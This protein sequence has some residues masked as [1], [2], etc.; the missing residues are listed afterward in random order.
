MSQV[1]SGENWYENNN[2]KM[3]NVYCKAGRTQILPSSLDLTYFTRLMIMVQEPVGGKF[4]DV[5]VQVHDRQD[6]TSLMLSSRP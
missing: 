5:T 1:Y 3:T 4:G 2:K 6:V